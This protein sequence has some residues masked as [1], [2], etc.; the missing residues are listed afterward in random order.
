M[1][2]GDAYANGDTD[3]HPNRDTNSDTD[4]D[5][6][7]Y[8]NADRYSNIFANVVRYTDCRGLGDS[9]D[10]WRKWYGEN[11]DYLFFSDCDGSRF[12]V[13]EEAKT[14]GVATDVFR[15]WSSEQIDY[16][17]QPVPEGSL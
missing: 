4:S 7:A 5:G 12:L 2:A 9:A 15:T 10:A 3:D 13:D 6:Y 8:R 11:K 14:A 17:P 1:E 16:R